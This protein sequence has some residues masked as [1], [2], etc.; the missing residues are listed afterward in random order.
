MRASSPREIIERFAPAP[1]PAD[2]FLVLPGKEGI[3]SLSPYAVDDYITCPLKY[4]Y[5]HILR[6]PLLRHHTVVFGEAVH[7]VL[8]EYFKLKKQGKKVTADEIA[9]MYEKYWS[10]AGFLSREHEEERYRVGK[11]NLLRYYEEQEKSGI[12]PFSLE[13]DFNSCSAER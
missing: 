10:S 13:E 3:L 7:N 12:I 4:K 6:V 1:D 5:I 8:N 9:A 2:K 11:E